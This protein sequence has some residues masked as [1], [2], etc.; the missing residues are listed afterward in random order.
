[1]VNGRVSLGPRVD[2]IFEKLLKPMVTSTIPVEQSINKLKYRVYTQGVGNQGQAL[3]DAK[4]GAGEKLT[5]YLD[6]DW[7]GAIAQTKPY[8]TKRIDETAKFEAATKLEET[9]VKNRDARINREANKEEK[10]RE[11]ERAQAKRQEE[12]EEKARKKEEKAAEKEEAKKR[13]REE[14]EAKNAAKAAAK[15]AAREKKLKKDVDRRHASS[16]DSRGRE[17]ICRN[18]RPSR[19]RNNLDY[20]V[21]NGDAF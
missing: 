1:M 3:V 19:K 8:T 11:K 18:N 7:R 6:E 21:L 15:I 20:R 14:K 2:V 12:R 13:K 17:H 10:Q 4:M 5:E 9:A 16:R